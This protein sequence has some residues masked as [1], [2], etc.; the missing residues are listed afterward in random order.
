[1]YDSMI[2][3]RVRGIAVSGLSNLYNIVS[4]HTTTA[5]M[6]VL[7]RIKNILLTGLITPACLAF[8]STH[9]YSANLSSSP[10]ASIDYTMYRL[11]T[12]YNDPS[13]QY[14]VGRNYLKGKS[15]EKNIKEAIK[16]FE[17]AAKQNH[18]RA[19]YQLGRLYLHGKEI[20][21]NLNFAF[22]YL[23][24]AAEKNH[25]ESQF[26][27][28]NFYM[29]GNANSRQYA[30]AAEWYRKAASRGHVRSMFELG[31]LLHQ[32]LGVEQDIT[33]A[34]RF[35]TEA[36]DSGLLEATTYLAQLNDTDVPQILTE[37]VSTTTLTDDEEIGD[38]T[39]QKE[40][41]LVRAEPTEENIDHYKLGI[42]Y[43]TGDGKEK[44]VYEAAQHFKIAANDGHG[45]AQYQLAK[46]Y[47]QGIGVKQDIKLSRHWLEKASTA[48]VISA[49]RDLQKTSELKEN[50]TEKKTKK[51]QNSDAETQ[52]QLGIQHLTGNE[53][54]MDTS[55]ASKL[56]LNAAQQDHA[57][58]QYQ[59]GIMY[60]KAIGFE[61]DLKKAREWYQKAANA[62]LPEA[63]DALSGLSISENEQ[64]IVLIKTPEKDDDPLDSQLID[65][66]SDP[67]NFFISKAKNGDRAAQYE[68]GIGFLNGEN[69]FTKDIQKGIDWLKTAANNHYTKAGTRLGLLYYQGTEVK[70]DYATAMKWLEKSAED[71]DAEA[72]F[73]M[74]KIYQRGLGVE[75]NNTTAMMWYRKAANQGHRG[76][77]KKLGGC[78]IC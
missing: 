57:R 51:E 58:A 21:T 17:M 54:V 43:L 44:N 7:N 40:F 73:T 15:V 39:T 67:I 35:V 14:L 52:F 36:A 71:G 69:G 2:K 47:E 38:T 65:K 75:K 66:K 63:Q 77:R 16:W 46:L 61:R 18:L 9:T 20:K 29:K 25:L 49:K 28:A 31:K 22:Y 1:M 26:E 50:K 48:G 13:A 4:R 74:G 76:A 19:Q 3:E 45:K 55:K 32:G 72:Q 41:S 59:L 60:E 68:V 23:S 56:L 10:E 53:K 8:I 5:C 11:A 42:A 70:R 34:R 24:K 6:T 78:R 37:R 30:K 62:G 27:L 64:R 12:E 33:Q